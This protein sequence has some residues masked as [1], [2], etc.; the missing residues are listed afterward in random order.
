MLLGQLSPLGLPV[1]HVE[2]GL[3]SF[4]MRMPE[5]LNRVLTDRVAT[6]L[7]CPSRAAID[8]LHAEG[9]RD[10][11]YDVG[12]VMADALAA[13]RRRAGDA[14]EILVKY[15][16]DNSSYVLATVHRA[17]NTDDGGRLQAILSALSSLPFPVIL[18]LHPRS[19]KHNTLTR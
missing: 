3:R 17:A 5:E 10:G 4:D 15:A 16:L 9:I 11:I 7:F 14:S 6:I 1:A 12:D 19:R 2:A 18:P 8:N 13:A